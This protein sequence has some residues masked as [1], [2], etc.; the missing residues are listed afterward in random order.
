MGWPRKMYDLK[1][2]DFGHGQWMSVDGCMGTDTDPYLDFDNLSPK[3]LEKAVSTKENI[4]ICN[5][6]CCLVGWVRHSFNMPARPCVGG[7]LRK[8]GKQFLTKFLELAGYD[9]HDPDEYDDEPDFESYA[10]NCFEGF[11]LEVRL[12]ADKAAKVWSKTLKH[13]GYTDTVK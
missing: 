9:K 10:S 11:G 6:Q 12:K 3:E 7:P 5:T 13:F 2:K 4:D 8:E 1:E